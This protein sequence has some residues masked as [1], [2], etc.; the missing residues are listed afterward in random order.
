MVVGHEVLVM[1]ETS[2][3]RGRSLVFQLYD[4][5]QASKSDTTV[6]GYRDCRLRDTG[7]VPLL[8][9]VQPAVDGDS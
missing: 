1:Y 7:V 8:H 6:H 5:C 4:N 9:G 2:G 3:L